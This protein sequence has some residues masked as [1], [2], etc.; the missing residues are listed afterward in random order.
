MQLQL[1]GESH[2]FEGGRVY[3]RIGRED[4]AIKLYLNTK[5]KK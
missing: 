2:E 4:I 3:K 5:N 1:E